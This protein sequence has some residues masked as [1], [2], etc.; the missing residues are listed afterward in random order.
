MKAPNN[1][2]FAIAD[3][4]TIELR[5]LAEITQDHELI[6]ALH[7]GKDLHEKTARAI[8][9]YNKEHEITPE[10]RKIGKVVNFGLIYG[11]TAHGLQKK[12]TTATGVEISLEQAEIFR[13]RYF[14][15]YP[16]VIRYQDRMLKAEMI[17]TLGG[18]YWSNENAMLKEGAIA[19]YN[20]PIQ[21]TG[22]E[23]FKESL[24]LLIPL[25]PPNLKLIAAIHDE[26]VIQV[27]EQDAEEAQKLLLEVMREGMQALIRSIPI[28]ID[29][30]ISDHWTK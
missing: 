16:A 17:S 20:Y 24:G 12:I 4:S 8:F 1:F 2:I 21:G 13:N 29:I 9:N 10:E 22:A 30:K 27:P 6:N 18:R 28:C 11:M 23:G 14:N 15:L 26:I 3:Y 7:N 25:I 19:R 5:I